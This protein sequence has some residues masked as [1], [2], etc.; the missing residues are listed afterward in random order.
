MLQ[1]VHGTAWTPSS[2]PL[3]RGNLRSRIRKPSAR[4]AIFDISKVLDS[5]LGLNPIASAIRVSSLQDSAEPSA[6]SFVRSFVPPCSVSCLQ[7]PQ[8]PRSELFLTVPTRRAATFL[9]PRAP[10]CSPLA[11]SLSLS[12][13][14]VSG[15]INGRRKEQKSKGW[16]RAGPIVVSASFELKRTLSH[17]CQSAN[18]S[19]ESSR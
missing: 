7:E 9:L 12:R 11:S 15:E 6:R 5:H 18:T 13:R 8:D 1:N 10:F 4:S 16:I 14:F 3:R 19:H 17:A 2:W